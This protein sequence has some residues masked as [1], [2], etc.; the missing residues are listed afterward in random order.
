L[1]RCLPDHRN[2]VLFVDFQGVGT[3]G[4]TIQSGAEKIKMHGHEVSIRAR[5]ETVENLSGHADYGEIFRW[6][7]GFPKAPR[8]TFL[9]HGEPSAAGSLKEKITRQ[10]GW[11][12]SVA[13]HLQKV[14]L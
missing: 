6:L 8:K 5:V 10:L 3:R 4:R 11:D 12:A 14:P 7:G 13:A 9:V 1:E 2:T